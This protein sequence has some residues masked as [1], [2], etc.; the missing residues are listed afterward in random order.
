MYVQKYYSLQLA[1]GSSILNI[2]LEA[3]CS[4]LSIV[5]VQKYYRLQ[6]AIGSSILNIRLEARN[7]I[8]NIVDL[9]KF[10][11]TVCSRQ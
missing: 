3:R 4:I 2:R 5:D 1:V 6:Q 9:Q 11:S 10:Y 8:L 7:S